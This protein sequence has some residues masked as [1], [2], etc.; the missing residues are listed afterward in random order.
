MTNQQKKTR[1]VSI[2]PG[3]ENKHPLNN[4]SINGTV[5]LCV[6]AE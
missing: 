6:I 2:N 5:S 4:I 1:R 3:V